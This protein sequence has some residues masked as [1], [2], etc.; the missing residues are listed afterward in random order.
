MQIFCT[1]YSVCQYGQI[2]NGAGRHAAATVIEDPLAPITSQ[3]YAYAAQI[4]LFPALAFS[5]LS[6]CLTYLRIFYADVRGRYMIQALMVLLVLLIIPF[7]FEAA[8]QCRP[9]RVYWTEGRPNSK[10]LENLPVVLTSGILNTFIDISL[11]AIVLPRILE[12]QLHPRQKLALTATVLLGSFAVVA[13]IVRMIRVGTT[14]NMPNYEPSWDSYDVSIW[15]STEIYVSL[16][17]ASVP[18]IKPVVVKVLPKLLGSSLQRRMR[19]V[20]RASTGMEM[21]LGTKSK[22]TTIGS[23]RINRRLSETALATA[24]EPYTGFGGDI[25]ARSLNGKSEE[26]PGTANS[27]SESIRGSHAYKISEITIQTHVI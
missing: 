24:D 4:L 3:K 18:G 11:M 12:L 9:V 15:T 19:T 10:C 25:Y 13:G 8:F 7:D 1:G 21:G 27:E 17:C 14:I 16:L 5:K 23:A 22:R 2:D 6:I 26:R 20:R